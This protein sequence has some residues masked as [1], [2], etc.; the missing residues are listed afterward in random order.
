M[1]YS[2]KLMLMQA[3]AYFVQWTAVGTV[4]GLVYKS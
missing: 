3:A 1:N 2:L 4:L